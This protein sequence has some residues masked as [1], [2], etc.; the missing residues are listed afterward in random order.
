MAAEFSIRKS[1]NDK[2]HYVLIA[3]NGEPVATSQMYTPKP[4][5]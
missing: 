2:F 4:E 1:K 3:G 5:P